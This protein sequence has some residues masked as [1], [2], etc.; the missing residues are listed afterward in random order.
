[1]TG[2]DVVVERVALTAAPF[3]AGISNQKLAFIGLVRAAR[4]EARDVVLPNLVQFRPGAAAQSLCPFGDIFDVA[5]IEH[6]ADVRFVEGDAEESDPS[7]LFH[8]ASASIGE[9]QRTGLLA[10]SEVLRLAA[11]LRPTPSR[12]ALIEDVA[13]RFRARGGHIV[14]QMRVEPDWR[15]YLDNRLSS[16]IGDTQ[17]LTISPIAIAAKIKATFGADI[18]P[19]LVTCDEAQVSDRETLAHAIEAATGLSV[20]FK[21][22]LAEG[23]SLPADPLGASLLDFELMAQA[24]AMIGTTLSSFFGLAALTRLGRNGASAE[25]W[26]YNALGESLVRRID[27]GAFANVGRATGRA[28]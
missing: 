14:C 16:R 7:R 23:E 21:S 20:L 15:D 28:A 3:E 10:G 12:Q 25:A 17:D 19:V 9:A 5:A 11:A 2:E 26:A 13:R 24:D 22:D 18:G 4:S 27:D 6:E 8:A 1:M